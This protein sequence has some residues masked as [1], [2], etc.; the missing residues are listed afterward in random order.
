[1]KTIV[2]LIMAPIVAYFGLNWAAANPLLL[3]GLRNKVDQRVETGYEFALFQY[4]SYSSEP[5]Q[6]TKKKKKDKKKG[7]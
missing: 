7:D 2:K 1:M 6:P 3:K 4:K 5:A